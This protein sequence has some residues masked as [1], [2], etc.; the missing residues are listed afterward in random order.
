M[1]HIEAHPKRFRSLSEIHQAYGLRKPQHPLISLT[2]FDEK[3]PGNPET[4]PVYNVLD[5]YKIT[6]I[7]QSGGRLKYGKNYYDFEEGS[8]LFLAPNQLVGNTKYSEGTVASI[9]LV[10]PDFLLGYPLAK[11]IKQYNYFSYEVNEALHLSDQEKEII[12][13]VYC[14]IE[15]ELASRLDEFSQ[16]VIIAQIELL[17]SYANRFY[18]RQFI[19]RKAVNHDTSKKIERILN[20]YFEKDQARLQGLPTVQMLS[21]ELHISSGYLSDLL[22]SLTGLNAQQYIHLKLIEFPFFYLTFC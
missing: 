7:T 17:L 8:M 11:K 21:D 19:T 10:H 1:K 13:S 16:N 6:L 4:A 18:R 3:N 9:L 14:I 12:F 5:F 20:D 22:R 2:N 15:Q